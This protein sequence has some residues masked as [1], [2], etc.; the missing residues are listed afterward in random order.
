R[1]VDRLGDQI[2]ERQ[3]NHADG[4]VHGFLLRA[5]CL[6]HYSTRQVKDIARTQRD[7]VSRLAWTEAVRVPIRVGQRLIGL[8]GVVEEDPPLFAAQTLHDEYI[9]DIEVGRESGLGG[10]GEVQIDL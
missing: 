1:S 6:V 5:E 2:K 7:W 8:T 9:C 10:R 3:R 4:Q